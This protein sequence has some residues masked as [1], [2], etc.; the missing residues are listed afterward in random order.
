M[1]TG[2]ED[3]PQESTDQN[4]TFHAHGAETCT[5]EAEVSF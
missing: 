3:S 1:T 4:H 5:D 2:S